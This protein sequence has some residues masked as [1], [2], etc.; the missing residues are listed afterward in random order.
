MDRDLV[1]HR[2]RWEEQ[3]VF[4]PEEARRAS[5]QRALPRILAE[6]ER[7]WLLKR[8]G[9]L[10]DHGGRRRR[11]EITAKVDRFAYQV[12]IPRNQAEHVRDPLSIRRAGLTRF[13]NSVF[14]KG[15][16]PSSM[17][18]GPRSTTSE[19]I[20]TDIAQPVLIWRHPA[21][22][23]VRLLQAGCPNGNL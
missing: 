12:E 15:G 6:V 23:L 13:F 7:Q 1:R 3:R 17:R 19:L 21:G 18:F 2:A 20:V 5:L 11:N 8:A 16:R 22:S 9:N 14:E 4:L 10:E